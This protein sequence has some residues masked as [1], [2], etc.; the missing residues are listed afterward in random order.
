VHRAHLLVATRARDQIGLDVVW[1]LP[2]ARAPHKLQGP[3]ASA[4]QRLAMCELAVADEEGLE[5]CRLELDRPAGRRSIETLAEL[6]QMHPDAEFWFLMGEDSFR[7]LST[8]YRPDRLARESH[9]VVQ[10]RPPRTGEYPASFSGQPLV[11]LEGEAVD[12][13]S[14]DIRAELGRG[15]TP[16]S[17]TPAVLDYIRRH[18]LYG[19]ASSGSRS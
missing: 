3:A 13:S 16:E 6:Q 7:D 11:W 12:M 18:G 8:W 15:G 10:A 1:L 9:L 14:S 2:A 19:A 4:E 17:L 5:V